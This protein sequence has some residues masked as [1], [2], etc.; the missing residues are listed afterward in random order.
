M[1]KLVSAS[2]SGTSTDASPFASSAT[3]GF[4]KSSVSNSSRVALCPPP[5]PAGTALRPKCRAPDDL[6]LRRRRLDAVGAPLQHGVE[7]VPAWFGISSSSASSTAASAICVPAGAGLPPG[8]TTCT[9]TCAFARTGYDLRIGRHR[10]GE[11]LCAA[12]PTLI[13]ASP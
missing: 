5:P 12:V 8:S 10:D 1:R 3:R 7:H 2:F 9:F 4:H 6:H 13:S 11:T